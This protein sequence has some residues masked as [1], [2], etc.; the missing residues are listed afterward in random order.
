MKVEMTVSLLEKRVKQIPVSK[1]T[2]EIH[3]NYNLEMHSD[4]IV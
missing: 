1:W 4:L 3:K 2:E